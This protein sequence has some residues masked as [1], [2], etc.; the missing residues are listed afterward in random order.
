MVLERTW[1]WP[2]SIRELLRTC[3]GCCAGLDGQVGLVGLWVL[4]VGFLWLRMSKDSS[5]KNLEL[6]SS[7]QA[8]L[9]KPQE[10]SYLRRA[11]WLQRRRHLLIVIVVIRCSLRPS[12]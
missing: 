1:Y 8:L 12:S 4:V 5:E 11:P 7:R 9:E 10:L 2:V 6:Q 3:S